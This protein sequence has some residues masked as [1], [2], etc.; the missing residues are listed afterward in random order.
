MK[1]LAIVIPVYKENLS[2]NEEIALEQVVKKLGKYEI[3]FLAPEGLQIRR[4]NT[5]IKYQYFE[6][7]WFQNIE[8]YSAF[9]LTSYLYQ[10]FADY[11][12]IL[13]YQ[14]DAFVFGD[15]ISDYMKMNFDYIGAPTLEGMYKPYRSEKVLF[16]QNGGF[17][18]RKVSAFRNWCE[19]NEQEISLMKKYDAEDSI[20]YALRSKG[21]NL[22]PIDVALQFSFDSNVRE[23]FER[24]N[25]LLPLGCHA[26]ERYDFEFWEPFITEQGYKPTPP[27]A[28]KRIIKD[29]YSIRKYNDSWREK[30]SHN[31]VKKVISNLLYHFDNKVYVWGM[32]RHGYDAMQL[33]LG[34]GIEIVAFIDNNQ[35]R[36]QEGM[37]PCCAVHVNEVVHRELDIPIIVAMYHHVDACIYLEN[38][39]L[40]HHSNY[41]TY[42]E[43]FE[44][45]EIETMRG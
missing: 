2:I 37:F 1:D 35:E 26:W 8:S 11:V 40:H 30:Y 16:T 29:Y 44:A 18:L 38:Y 45:F 32:G 22:A 25:M 27:E 12:Y 41:I 15:N 14:L 28:G 34:A 36:I 13:V 9:M 42:M 10:R 7:K 3:F 33:L 4:D 6:R 21:L 19:S 17:S 31:I 24:N 5:T 20:I 43:L 23:C 39:G